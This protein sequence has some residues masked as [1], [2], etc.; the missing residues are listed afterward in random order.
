M[1][2]ARALLLLVL[3]VHFGVLLFLSA[4]KICRKWKIKSATTKCLI[5]ITPLTVF[6]LIV[7]LMDVLYNTGV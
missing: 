4:D 7:I 1:N 6:C 3:G 5:Y 2:L